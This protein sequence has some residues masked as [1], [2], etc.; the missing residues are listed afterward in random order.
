MQFTNDFIV[1][2]PP[3]RAW[4]VLQDLEQVAHCMPGATLLEN[5]GG[6]FT[7]TV[8]VKV[9]PITVKYKGSAEFI[10]KDADNYRMVLKANGREEQGAGTAGATVTAQLYP[11]DN[12][13]TRVQVLT[14][15]DITGKPAQFGRGV[16]AEVGSGII[17]QFAK[18]LAVQIESQSA[19]TP[20]NASAAAQP[21]V[22]PASNVAAAPVT[23][24]TM[25]GHH[26]DDALDMGMLAWKPALK[27]AAPIAAVVLGLLLLMRLFSR[28]PKTPQVVVVFGPT[29]DRR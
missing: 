24:A 18:R 10:E 2:V 29:S 28:Q 5:D 6:R 13:Q 9:G 11:A 8:K 7:G 19:A 3:A 23:A 12:G 25:S 15:L 20:Q 1:P 16:M 21:Q 27:R 22:Q 4:Q 14:D 17:R 26:E